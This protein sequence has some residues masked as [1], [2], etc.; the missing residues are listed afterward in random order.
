M[1]KDPSTKP[2]LRNQQWKKGDPIPPPPDKLQQCQFWLPRKLRYCQLIAK[3]TN[4]FCGEHMVAANEENIEEGQRRVPCPFDPSHSV[5]QK[6]L[7]I[8]KTKCNARP[9]S[10]EQHYAL[11][12]NTTLPLSTEELAFQQGIL[13][14][15]ELKSQPWIANIHL[16]ELPKPDLDALIGKV[17][18]A[19]DAHVPSPISKRVLSH[20]AIVT[21][22]KSSKL[23]RHLHQQSSLLGHMRDCG[24]LDDKSA[25]FVEFGAGK[26]ELSGHLKEALQ[27]ENGEAT[28]VLIDRKNVRNKYDKI[29]LGK[30]AQTSIVQRVMIDI[31]DLHLGKIKSLLTD[32]EKKKKPV[33][34]LSKHLCGSATDITL[35]CLMNYVDEEKAAGNSC[36]VNGIIIALC[37]HQ[38]CRYEMYPNTNY[39]ERIGLSKLEFD[40]LCKMTS[41]AI[42][43]R[44]NVTDDLEQ[45]HALLLEDEKEDDNGGHYSGRHHE[46]REKIG[47]QCKRVL[48][49]GRLDYLEQHGFKVHL[50]YYVDP[51]S[52]LENCALIALPQLD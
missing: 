32:Q 18:A 8:H 2:S 31:K 52:T 49:A 23:I 40:Q 41:W 12:V 25:C 50:V 4:R 29:L 15:K 46:D 11:N 28:Y 26:G 1:P 30:S 24:M 38:M 36:P 9:R 39:L 44:R 19:Y 45:E 47:Y 5:I 51:T 14:H 34:C 10:P 35:K 13:S 42:C 37:C 20:P 27:E 6:D 33:V 22:G 3:K 21:D 16:N 43:G 48:D 17:Q 7:D